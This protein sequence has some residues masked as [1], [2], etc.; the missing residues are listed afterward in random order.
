M[1]KI[2][3]KQSQNSASKS[4]KL[5]GISLARAKKNVAV[6]KKLKKYGR[7]FSL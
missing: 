1:L 4:S 6:I 7:A 3:N 5:E 2:N